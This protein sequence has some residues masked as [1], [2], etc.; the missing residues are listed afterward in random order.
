MPPTAHHALTIGA[1][2]FDHLTPSSRLVRQATRS[3]DHSSLHRPSFADPLRLAFRLNSANYTRSSRHFAALHRRNAII[4]RREAI[5]NVYTPPPNLSGDR[6]PSGIFL[7]RAICY[8]YFLPR[9][10]LRPCMIFRT[11]P[12][13][14]VIP[15][16]SK[17]AAS[18]LLGNEQ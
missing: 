7:L 12:F 18:Y 5:E 17:M 4:F 3:P 16:R 9:T 6:A 2:H 8:L 11:P 14:Y 15:K 13:V 1:S 10:F